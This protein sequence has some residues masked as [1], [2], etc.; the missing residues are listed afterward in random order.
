MITAELIEDQKKN[1]LYALHDKAE[2]LVYALRD[3]LPGREIGIQIKSDSE[4]YWIDGNRYTIKRSFSFS[5][6]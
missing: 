2:D 5:R 6:D 4:E 1:D 3:M